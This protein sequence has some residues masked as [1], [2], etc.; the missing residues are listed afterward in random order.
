[1]ELK[2]PHLVEA[3]TEHIKDGFFNRI[4]SKSFPCVGAKAALARDHIESF[5]IEDMASSRDDENA[6]QFLYSFVENYRRSPRKFHSAALFFK[7]PRLMSEEK[8]D[9]LMWQRLQALSDLDA[10]NYKYDS[11]VN[12][13]PFSPD[14]SFSL[15]EEAFFI[16][17]LHPQSSRLARQFEHPVLIFN[18]HAQFEQLR[19]SGKFERMQQTIRKRD[20]KFSGS[21]NPMLKNF[22]E[23]SEVWQYSGRKYN[24]N[25]QCPLKINHA[26]TSN[27]TA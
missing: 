4:N 3:N 20:I 25:W 16:I 15:K 26:N 27:S 17:G 9:E 23:S 14:F 1:M 10:R 11:R 13:D 18:P 7:T 22:G 2:C 6:L 12:A 21:V 5:M 8:F 24:D 19:K